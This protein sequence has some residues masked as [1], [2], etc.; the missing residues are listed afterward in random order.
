M[1][2]RMN[3]ASMIGVICII[4]VLY[5]KPIVCY[6]KIIWQCFLDQLEWLFSFHIEIRILN[7]R[8]MNHLMIEMTGRYVLHAGL[9]KLF[10][11][12]ILT[13]F[14]KLFCSLRPFKH[15]WHDQGRIWPHLLEAWRFSRGGSLLGS[16]T[17]HSCN[18]GELPRMPAGNRA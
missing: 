6:Y 8:K 7:V 9:Y 11:P 17:S 4:Y 5:L 10:P 15:Y 14:C 18:S 13:A 1:F 16:M 2:S 12:F 3:I